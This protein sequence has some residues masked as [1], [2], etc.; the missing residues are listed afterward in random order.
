MLEEQLE[1]YTEDLKKVIEFHGHLCPGLAY[2]YRISKAAMEYFGKRALDEELVVI[3]ENKSCAVDAIQV[4]TGCTF[5]K[6][7]LIHKDYGKQVY[8]FYI[9]NSGEAVRF[10]VDFHYQE[11]E[12]EK[13]VW[14][15]FLNGN[16]SPEI[17]ARVT[18]QKQRKTRAI[19]MAPEADL[20]KIKIVKMEPPSKAGLFKNFRCAICGEKMMEPRARIKN[21]RTV[22]I[23]CAGPE[24]QSQ[25]LT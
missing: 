12:E 1:F 2:G 21:G 11:T 15:Q 22:C 18:E 14:E 24:Y 9:R 17:L 16:E 4:I 20:L 3:V 8:T 10:S 7:N 25:T 13:A 6:G 19:L 5:G 23:P